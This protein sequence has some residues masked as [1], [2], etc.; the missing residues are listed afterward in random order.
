[1]LRTV[2]HGGL[3]QWTTARAFKW[4]MWFGVGVSFVVVE[5]EEH[6]LERPAV[7]VGNHQT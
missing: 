6:L 4:M 1:M 2:G 7:F 3:S 5:G